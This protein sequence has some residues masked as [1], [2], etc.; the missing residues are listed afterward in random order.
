MGSTGLMSWW[1]VNASSFRT[2]ESAAGYG[3]SVPSGLGVSAHGVRRCADWD[4]PRPGPEAR[5]A[6]VTSW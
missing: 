2:V 4:W 5:N 3:G 6:S 1:V